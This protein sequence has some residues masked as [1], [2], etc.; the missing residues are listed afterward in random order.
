MTLWPREHG[1]GSA[2]E[3]MVDRMLQRGIKTDEIGT[4]AR[5]NYI[6][7]EKIIE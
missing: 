6:L 1:K 7:K 2:M 4:P 3:G 5:K